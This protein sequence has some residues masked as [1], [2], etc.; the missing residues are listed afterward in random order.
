MLKATLDC[1]TCLSLDPTFAKAYIRKANVFFSMKE[2]T[3][4]MEA[5]DAGMAAGLDDKSI[6]DLNE[7]KMKASNAVRG[8]S[9]EERRKNAMKDPA[10]MVFFF[11]F[12][13]IKEKS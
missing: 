13:L 3:K 10:V 8:T 12:L 4:C 6:A 1:E 7:W 2:Y 5:C 9:P 11:S